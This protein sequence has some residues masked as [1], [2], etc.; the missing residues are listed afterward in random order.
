MRFTYTRFSGKNCTSKDT[1]ANKIH[2][3]I[4]TK[5]RRG[6]SRGGLDL[7]RVNLAAGVDPLGRNVRLAPALSP[8]VE[9]EEAT[10]VSQRSCRLEEC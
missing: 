9:E 8:L 1:F 6:T 7:S 3:L 4:E 5:I 2:Q 10:D